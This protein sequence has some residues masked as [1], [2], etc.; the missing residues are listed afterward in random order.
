M[1]GEINIERLMQELSEIMSEK[2]GAKITFT[3]IRK[4][5]LENQPK[6]AV[7]GC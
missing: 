4:E 7:T 6:Y 3:A 5:E 2:Y 1:V